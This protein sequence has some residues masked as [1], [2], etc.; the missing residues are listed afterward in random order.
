MDKEELKR[1]VMELIDADDFHKHLCATVDKIINSGMMNV[2]SEET[3]TYTLAKVV[4][5]CALNEQAYSYR[6]LSDAISWKYKN[7]I[8]YYAPL[9]Q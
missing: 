1:I 2:E 3:G 8:R 4:L 7:I 9:K 6:P 5:Y